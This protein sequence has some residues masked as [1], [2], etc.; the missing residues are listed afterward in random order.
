[1]CNE[2]GSK[3]QQGFKKK[4]EWKIKLKQGFLPVLIH[5]FV[6]EQHSWL[7]I[8]GMWTV[9]KIYCGDTVPSGQ[10]K[11][12]QKKSLC[13]LQFPLLLSWFETYPRFLKFCAIFFSS[14]NL[15]VWVLP[16]SSAVLYS[17]GGGCPNAISEWQTLCCSGHSVNQKWV[18]SST[19]CLHSDR[20]GS[21]WKS[22]C[23]QFGVSFYTA[24]G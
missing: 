13:C 10:F 5:V 12:T 14:I 22:I 19:L 21:L 11:N 15:E 23:D 24:C 17:W 4:H 2:M 8:C 20:L 6:R 18:S 3:I 1:M 7:K 16:P 9:G